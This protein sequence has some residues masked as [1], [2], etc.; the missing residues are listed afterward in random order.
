MFSS[1]ISF[2]LD[3]LIK[4]E[5]NSNIQNKKNKLAMAFAYGPSDVA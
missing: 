1:I 3:N 5:N 2:L 4:Y